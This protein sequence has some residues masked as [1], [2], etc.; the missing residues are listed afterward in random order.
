MRQRM[1]LFQIRLACLVCLPLIAAC[2]GCSLLDLGGDD[3]TSETE[4]SG[5]EG[6]ASETGEEPEVGLRVY[7]KYMDID[8]QAVVTLDVNDTPTPCPPDDDDGG[9][10]CDISRIFTDTALVRVEKEGFE[11][12]LVQPSIEQGVIQSVD[13][14][15]EPAG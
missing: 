9:Y 7:P 1:S 5:A 12:A 15:L 14:P 2:V 11:T 4:A 3:G 10:L 8:V 6:E 13:V